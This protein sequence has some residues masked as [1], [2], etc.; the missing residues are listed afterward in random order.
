MWCFYI[1]Y[2]LQISDM[3]VHFHRKSSPKQRKLD[4]LVGSMPSLSSW[5]ECLVWSSLS[6]PSINSSTITVE[7]NGVLL[8]QLLSPLWMESW[9]TPHKNIPEKWGIKDFVNEERKYKFLK[10]MISF[11]P[12]WIMMWGFKGNDE[13]KRSLQGQ[14]WLSNCSGSNNN[15]I[16]IP[17]CLAQSF[18]FT[19]HG[20]VLHEVIDVFSSSRS[21]R[22]FN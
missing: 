22:I 5:L 8:A 13:A 2:L 15:A 9:R 3:T 19:I 16:F 18:I 21:I 7:R 6:L 4:I 20:T 11:I 1:F 12:M 10:A 14:I 17:T